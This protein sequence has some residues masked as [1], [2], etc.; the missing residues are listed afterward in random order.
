MSRRS[1]KCR[2]VPERNRNQRRDVGYQRRDVPEIV[3]NQRRDVGNKRRDVPD[4]FKIHVATLDRYPK[5]T[6][7]RSNFT[8]RRSREGKN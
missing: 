2:D 4:A 8:S 5:S 6:S 7:R 1:G 3:K